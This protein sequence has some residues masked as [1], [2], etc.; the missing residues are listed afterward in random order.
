MSGYRTLHRENTNPHPADEDGSN[1]KKTVIPLWHTLFSPCAQSRPSH[2]R[3]APSSSPPLRFLTASADGYVRAYEISDKEISRGGEDTMLDASALK[4]KMKHVLLGHNQPPP[5]SSPQSKVTDIGYSK[6]DIIRNYVGEDTKSGDEVVVALRLDGLVRLWI[7]PQCPPYLTTEEEQQ[8]EDENLIQYSTV[9]FK[10]KESTGT[11]IAIRP[12]SH[13]A[14]PPS[15]SNSSKKQRIQ[16]L[17]VAIANLNGSI[18]FYDSGIPVHNHHIP[19]SQDERQQVECEPKLINSI[20]SGGVIITS[21]V[22]H[23]SQHDTIAVGRK[24]G[25]IDVYAPSNYESPGG[26][27]A[28]YKRLH[29]F[30]NHFKPIRSLTFSSSSSSNGGNGSNDGALLITGSDDGHIFIYDIFSR[31]TSTT[32][33]S[34]IPNAHT[35]WILS[36]CSIPNSSRFVTCGADGKIKVWDTSLVNAGAVHTFDTVGGK[37]MVWGVSASYDSRKMISCD[38]NG[39]IQVYSCEE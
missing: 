29:H 12:P 25:T 37:N 5:A 36:T 1:S 26:A 4:L 35:S 34:S 9:E 27:T 14:L 22:Y 33:V 3:T 18:S 8:Q 2:H 39:M 31:S 13:S 17:T 24:D 15:S 21:I 19:E 32:M 30:T 20:G 7:R 10:V 23:P 11:S 16:N 6:I 38:D 28:A